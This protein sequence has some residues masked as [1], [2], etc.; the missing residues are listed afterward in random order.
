[1]PFVFTAVHE[2]A[3]RMPG[4]DVKPDQF[5]ANLRHVGVI[6]GAPGQSGNSFG[7]G[8]LPSTHDATH[9]VIAITDC[10][11]RGQ[12]WLHNRVTGNARA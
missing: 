6:A 11:H 10:D 3:H 8:S 12:D 7:H 4:T 2:L 5:A 9:S 1:M